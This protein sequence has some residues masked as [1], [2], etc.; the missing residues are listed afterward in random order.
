M[1]AQPTKSR[2]LYILGDRKQSESRRPVDGIEKVDRRSV[3][4]AAAEEC[5]RFPADVITG[6]ERL[7]C[8]ARQEGSC[9]VVRIVAAVAKRYPERRIDEYHRYTTSSIAAGSKSSAPA[10]RP[11]GS[12]DSGGSGLRRSRTKSRIKAA[13]DVRA[14]SAARSNSASTSSSIMICSRFTK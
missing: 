3:S 13:F 7:P 4:S 14:S 11:I 10:I 9:E 12:A 8:V 5:P 2:S 1:A 6:Q